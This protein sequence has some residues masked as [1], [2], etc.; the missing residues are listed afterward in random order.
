M[1]MSPPRVRTAERLRVR[2]AKRLRQPGSLRSAGDRKTALAATK[3]ASER[4]VTSYKSWKA[5]ASLVASVYSGRMEQCHVPSREAQF[6]RLADVGLANI[7]YAPE[8]EMRP[9]KGIP[10]NGMRSPEMVDWPAR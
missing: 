2:T 6:Q 1:V 7:G 8:R 3:V 10:G 5:I 4:G 9:E